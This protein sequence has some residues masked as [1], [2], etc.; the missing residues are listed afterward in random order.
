[1]QNAAI[2]LISL[3]SAF[4]DDSGGRAISHPLSS[5][6]VEGCP[7]G[8]DLSSAFG[9][10]LF[11]GATLLACKNGI[12]ERNQYSLKYENT[13]S[14]TFPFAPLRKPTSAPS[15]HLLP[16]E[17]G[18]IHT[19]PPHKSLPR[20]RNVASE[21]RRIGQRERKSVSSR[22]CGRPST[23]EQEYIFPQRGYKKAQPMRAALSDFKNY[24]LKRK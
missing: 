6:L 22:R 12:C 13:A 14:L 3:G 10:P 24:T 20:V 1:M 9:A 5:L 17:G 21:A 2:A 11:Q 15:G 19:I 4:D 16:K 23:Q 18:N 8:A 7:Y